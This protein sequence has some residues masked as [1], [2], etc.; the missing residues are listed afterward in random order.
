MFTDTIMFTLSYR[1]ARAMHVV[2]LNQYVTHSNC[3]I[4]QSITH[5]STFVDLTHCFA[6]H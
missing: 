6:W 1:I 5:Q 2:S 3:F 4:T